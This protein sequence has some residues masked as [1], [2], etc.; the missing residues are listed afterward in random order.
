MALIVFIIVCAVVLWVAV[1]LPLAV[2]IGRISH[3]A[4]LGSAPRMPGV[5]GY[6]STGSFASSTGSV[7]SITR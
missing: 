5:V 1:S 6:R 4:D 2:I 3:R 7:G